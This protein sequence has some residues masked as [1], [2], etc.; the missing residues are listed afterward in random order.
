MGEGGIFESEMLYYANIL[1]KS[2]HAY[3]LI[4]I[5]RIFRTEFMRYTLPR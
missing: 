5:S 1:R 3:K 4:A 2:A